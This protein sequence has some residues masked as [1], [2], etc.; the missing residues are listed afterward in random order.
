[1]QIRI[2]RSSRTIFQYMYYLI[3]KEDKL[4]DDTLFTKKK[5][6]PFSSYSKNY[7]KDAE[8]HQT[9]IFHYRRF[10]RMTY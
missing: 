4:A 8:T 9:E 7:E 1:M 10:S 6:V 3:L 5:E 2:V